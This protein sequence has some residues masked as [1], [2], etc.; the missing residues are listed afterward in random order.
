MT[1]LAATSPRRRD[2]RRG[3]IVV[4]ITPPHSQYAAASGYPM[5]PCGPDQWTYVSGS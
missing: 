3:S 2:A 4:I 5:G 1:K